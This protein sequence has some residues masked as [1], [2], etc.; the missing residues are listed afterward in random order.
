MRRTYIDFGFNSVPANPQD[1]RRDFVGATFIA[2]V[3]FMAA[4]SA[5]WYALNAL[6]FTWLTS[7]DGSL[8]LHLKSWI[9]LLA[10]SEGETAQHYGAYVT[11]LI[12][13]EQILALVL[14]AS[15]ALAGAS[16]VSV[17]LFIEAFKPR[18]SLVHITGRRFFEGTK[19]MKIAQNFSSQEIAQS[20]L[21]INLT[22]NLTISQEREK[23][24]FL[25]MGAVGSGKTTIA[26][27]ILKAIFARKDKALIVDWKGDITSRYNESI[28]NPFDSRSLRWAIARDI[29]TEL[30]AYSFCCQLSKESKD[31]IW[32][33]GA[34]EAGTALVM[35]LQ[36]EKPG[37]WNFAD[38]LKEL[39]G[40]F[41]N[42]QRAVKYFRPASFSMYEE[43][44]KTTQS[45]LSTLVS[46]W[47]VISILAQ[48]D[49]DNPAA[50][51]FSI[52]DF[53]SEGYRGR[54]QIIIGASVEHQ[55]ISQ[56]YLSVL[57]TATA[58]RL[59][60]LSDNALR[61]VWFVCDEFPLI[62]H[63]QALETLV[64]FGRSKGARVCLFCQDINQV[65]KIYSPESAKS[66]LSM[67]GT[68]IIGKT[69]GGE[70]ADFIS[71][72]IIGTR[73]VE[74]KNLTTQ[75]G[76][77]GS[78]M[79]WQKDEMPV[80]YPSELESELGKDGKTGINALLLL[81]NFALKLKWSFVAPAEYREALCLR[82]CFSGDKSIATTLKISA[83]NEPLQT[84]ITAINLEKSEAV[85]I[86]TETVNHH[87][88]P[89][90]PEV[91]EGAL[92]V[93]PVIDLVV[94]SLSKP[95]MQLVHQKNTQ[96]IGSVEIDELEV[97]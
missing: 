39:S 88:A 89:V 92:S 44:S 29:R 87:I 69:S 32:S 47:S 79:S 46:D 81:D 22:E 11:Q 43:P 51:S 17:L 73:I 54:K 96:K 20:E 24:H 27:H 53:L 13:H 93:V 6:A 10:F 77:S 68:K 71:K 8:W 82:N 67:I 28:F 41:D 72:T 91:L 74:R 35:K 63:L 52:T 83:T 45:F 58:S 5:V 62:G 64:S 9:A 55:A 86:E 19:A 84:P 42:V 78:S 48:A 15:L 60:S 25:V 18:E 61:K 31:P 2:V 90:I 21:G 80:V 75:S 50:K 4:L 26:H 33:N 34:R 37:K 59:N 1:L 56:A 7:L 94:D 65:R 23:T 57:I 95:P 36:N 30:D 97:M 85:N 66:L 12:E 76:K 16:I 3:G 70:T 14:R 38:L 49:A 40:G